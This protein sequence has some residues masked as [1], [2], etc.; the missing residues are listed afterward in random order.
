M[1]VKQNRTPDMAAMLALVRAAADLGIDYSRLS[2]VK[3]AVALE[4]RV[5]ELTN[6]YRSEADQAAAAMAKLG[7]DFAEGKATPAEVVSRAASAAV[8]TGSRASEA[9]RHIDSAARAANAAGAR[10]LRTLTEEQWIAPIRPVVATLIAEA[11]VHAER[12]GMER[13]HAQRVG[14]REVQHPWAPRKSDLTKDIGLRH[15]WENL[16]DVLSRLDA[17]HDIADRLRIFGLVPM[18]EGRTFAEDYRWLHLD[19]LA[20][21]PTKPREFWMANRLNDAEPGVYTSTELEAGTLAVE[22]RRELAHDPYALG[23]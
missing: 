20:G 14:V 8:L 13:P 12:M 16:A 7:E 21:S 17:V 1:L 23:V 4:A 19:R 10:Q 2:A 5:V 22:A 15:A 6:T 18:I 11:N 9:R 3:K